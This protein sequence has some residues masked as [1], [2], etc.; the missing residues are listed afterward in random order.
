[1]ELLAEAGGQSLMA[2]GALDDKMHSHQ[3]VARAGL[4][5][6][7]LWTLCKS[8]VC[9]NL[10]D[11]FIPFEIAQRYA[12]SAKRARDLANALIDCGGAG[13]AGLWEPREGGYQM[14][15]YLDYDDSAADIRA[16]RE[17]ERV[18]KERWRN[19]ANGNRSRDASPGTSP[20]TSPGMSPVDNDRDATGESRSC[21]SDPTPTPTP[22]RERKPS[23]RARVIEA[24]EEALVPHGMAMAGGIG[25]LAGD[26]EAIAPQFG[27]DPIALVP[28]VF[29]A[30]AKESATWQVPKPPRPEL[31]SRHIR[32]GSIPAILA[33]HEP[34]LPGGRTQKTPR[35]ELVECSPPVEKN[36][37]MTEDVRR[38]L[39]ELN[40]KLGRR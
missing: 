38:G 3:K 17:A 21:P 27:G 23:A 37:P 5:A 18:K 13:R 19:R 29:K 10:T 22:G 31:V 33:G 6:I 36:E 16:R 28:R 32:N 12:G 4:E 24:V 14:H 25:D 39:E 15:D 35:P 9:D 2:W 20:V 26:I 40:R 30:F 7:G 11:G 8:W 1:M 34:R